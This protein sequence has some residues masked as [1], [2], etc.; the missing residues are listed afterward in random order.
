MDAK[1]ASRL[2]FIFKTQPQPSFLHGDIP[3]VTEK[4]TGIYK[5]R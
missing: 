2:F 1:Y 3:V 5:S 4:K